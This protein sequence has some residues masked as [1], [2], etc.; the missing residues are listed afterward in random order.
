LRSAAASSGSPSSGYPYGLAALVGAPVVLFEG[1]FPSDVALPAWAQKRQGYT[2]YVVA[3]PGPGTTRDTLIDGVVG[4][5]RVHI[6]YGDGGQRWNMYQSSSVFSPVVNDASTRRLIAARFDGAASRFTRDG[7]QSQAGNAGI[8][9]ANVAGIRIGANAAGNDP[10]RG[11]V[12]A[13]LLFA[14]PHTDQQMQVATRWL[15]TRYSQTVA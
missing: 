4:T 13:L 12:E 6:T 3:T 14:E 11:T 10:W 5:A 2:L 9:G 8:A 7:V 15:G 1:A